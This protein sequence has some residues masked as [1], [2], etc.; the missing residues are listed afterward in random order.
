MDN[1]T[2]MNNLLAVKERRKSLERLLV[3]TRQEEKELLMKVFTEK[4]GLKVGDHI[5][6]SNGKHGV[7]ES[8]SIDYRHDGDLE[9]KGGHFYPYKKDGSLSKSL[10][11]INYGFHKIEKVD[12]NV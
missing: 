2:M 12:A 10:Y 1:E 5:R 7:L 6:A 4:T 3:Q 9:I 8:L 11:R